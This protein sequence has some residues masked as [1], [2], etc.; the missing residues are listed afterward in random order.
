MS[1]PENGPGGDARPLAGRVALVAGGSK[2]IGRE[3]ALRFARAGA[4]VVIAARQ[5]EPAHALRREIE[6][7]GGSAACAQ[8]DLADC[9]AASAIVQTALDSFGKVD[10]MVVSGGDGPSLSALPFADTDPRSYPD[11]L[12]GQLLTRLNAIGAVL[13]AM[14]QQGYGKIVLVTTDAGRVPTPGEAL[15]GAAGAGLMF[16]VR[17]IGREIARFGVRLNAVSITIT[18]GTATWSGH[19]AGDVGSETLSS[20]FRKIEKLAA[21]R[22]NTPEDVAGAVFY[23]ASP[24]SD[25]VSGAVL[26]VNGGV[27]FP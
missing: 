7:L 17:A 1:A 20:V 4:D 16:A 15:Y 2:G 25:Q 8:G 24:E 13:P 26:S 22:V 21:F 11:Y 10:I 23:L 14:R 6:A 18:Q 12:V 3:C 5:Q 19:R 9:D 27:S